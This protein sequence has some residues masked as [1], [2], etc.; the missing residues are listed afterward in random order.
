MKRKSTAVWKGTG[1]EGKGNLTSTSG[2]LKNI[3]YSFSARFVSEDGKEGTNPEELIA[4]A[5]AG[6][7]AMALSFGLTAAGFK[8]TELKTDATVTVI[9]EPGGWVIQSSHLDVLGDI[10]NI[11]EAKFIELANEAKK[12]CPVSKALDAIDITLSAKLKREEIHVS[13]A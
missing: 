12:N 10:P 9:N 1:T 2:A 5:H 3:P 4:A 6:C 8:P 13:G 11:S 7:F